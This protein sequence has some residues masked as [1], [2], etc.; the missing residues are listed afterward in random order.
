M[1]IKA[2]ISISRD[3]SGV[4]RMRIR[5]DASRNEFVDLK[6][7]AESF[8]LAITGLSETECEATISKI[9]TVGMT[10]IRERR[11]SACPLHT[12]NK[13]TLE[14]WL[15]ENCQEPGW[16]LDTYIGSQESVIRDKD[17]NLFLNYSVVKYVEQAPKAGDS[18]LG[19]QK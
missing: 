15:K 14:N 2:R 16:T 19:E 9:E 6:I 1:E 7:S 5:D 12:Y 17:G 10:K 3:S 13:I 4:I 8:G 18:I 11:R